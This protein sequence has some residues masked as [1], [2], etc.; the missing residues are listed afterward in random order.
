MQSW[1]DG[2]PA[3]AL[4]SLKDRGLAYGD[5]L[6]ETIAVKASKPLLLDLHLQR[7]ALGCTRLA[8]A[9]DMSLIRSEL[10]AYAKAMGEGVLKFILTRGDSLRGYGACPEAHPRRIPA[11]GRVCW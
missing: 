7:L 1:V 3:N 5:G 8:I 4:A 9:A 11:A 2:R 6:F 10:L